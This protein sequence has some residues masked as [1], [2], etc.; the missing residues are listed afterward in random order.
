MRRQLQYD[1]AKR[2]A[3]RA[4]ERGATYREFRFPGPP[5]SLGVVL[6]SL[7]WDIAGNCYRPV[8]V[9]CY[10]RP[11]VEG[12]KHVVIGR[13]LPV[14]WSITMEVR[15]R[16]CETCLKKR[17]AHW[18]M[19]A[20]T[21]WSQAPRTWLVTLTLSPEAHYEDLLKCRRGKFKVPNDQQGIDF[22]A[23]PDEQ[24]SRIRIAVAGE[25]VTKFFKSLRKGD[26]D[27]DPARFRYML[28]A[29]TH[30]SGLPHFHVYF[31]EMHGKSPIRH[32][33]FKRFWKA[34]FLDAKLVETKATATYAT[35]YLVKS[36]GARVRASLDYGATC[37]NG[38]TKERHS[39]RGTKR[40][41]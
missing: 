35:K 41:V 14:T 29:E 20:L 5:G 37:M 22:D 2:L 15:C 36:L 17:A 33:T 31:H 11:T 38:V 26:K 23:L 4:M 13:K 19:K 34:G 9:E 21:E 10:S 7:K 28:V 16:K 40:S 39:E 12:S 25:R 27:N 3:L 32:K 6:N 18:R 24:K 8:T 30:K 1:R